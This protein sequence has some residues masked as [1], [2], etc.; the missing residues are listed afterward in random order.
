[1]P[2]LVFEV[3]GLTKVYRSSEVEVRALAGVDMALE[4]RGSWS[5]C[6][7]HPGP[8]NRRS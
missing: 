6:S 2:D 3:R 8:A 5:C 1:M 7:V 4:G